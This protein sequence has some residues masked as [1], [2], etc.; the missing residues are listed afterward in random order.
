[1]AGQKFGGKT[2]GNE[3]DSSMLQ[4]QLIALHTVNTGYHFLS[5]DS[6]PSMG[7]NM[8][9]LLQSSQQRHDVCNF[10]APFYRGGNQGAGM[11]S[12]LPKGHMV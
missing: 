2:E 12:N 8:H 7:L 1:M 6:I 4:Q 10:I 11:L 5:T 3:E 9:Y